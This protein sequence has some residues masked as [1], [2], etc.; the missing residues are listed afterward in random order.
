MSGYIQF[1]NRITRYKLQ[2]PSVLFPPE[3]VPIVLHPTGFYV[4]RALIQSEKILPLLQKIHEAIPKIAEGPQPLLNTYYNR[5]SCLSGILS[6]AVTEVDRAVPDGY[7]C[8]E[9][10][11]TSFGY[12]GQFQQYVPSLVSPQAPQLQSYIPALSQCIATVISTFQNFIETLR[13]CELVVKQSAQPVDFSKYPLVPTVV[14][15]LYYTEQTAV[16]INF[17]LQNEQLQGTPQ[18]EQL[19]NWLFLLSQFS[20]SLFTQALADAASIIGS[21]SVVSAASPSLLSTVSAI[22]QYC[23]SPSDFSKLGSNAIILMELLYSIEALSSVQYAKSLI[24]TCVQI[25]S[26]KTGQDDLNQFAN[27]LYPYVSPKLIDLGTEEAL[28]ANVA[29]KAA[30]EFSNSTPEL[31]T[32]TAVNLVRIYSCTCP[33]LDAG[34]VILS[35]IVKVSYDLINALFAVVKQTVQQIHDSYN[36]NL[37]ELNEQYLNEINYYVTTILGINA[38]TSSDDSLKKFAFCFGS[39]PRAIIKLEE[40]I[41]RPELK[42]VFQQL[43]AKCAAYNKEIFDW[44]HQLVMA[45]S[46]IVLIH[47]TVV[48]STLNFCQSQGWRLPDD[49][50]PIF[51]RLHKA[52]DSNT[53]LL[54]NDMRNIGVII[55][56]LNEITQPLTNYQMQLASIQQSSGDQLCSLA[57]LAISHMLKPL[58][59]STSALIDLLQ[60]NESDSFVAFVNATTDAGLKLLE[61]SLTTLQS[62]PY[63]ILFFLGSP[64]SILRC[65]FAAISQYPDF[66][67]PLFSFI[68]NASN[69]MQSLWNLCLS[70]SNGT[71]G[72]NE[73][74]S[75]IQQLQNLIQVVKD[76]IVT[77]NSLRAPMLQIELPESI[78]HVKAFESRLATIPDGLLKNTA[79]S[80]LN[81]ARNSQYAPKAFE[82][83]LNVIDKTLIDLIPFS[84]QLK[85]TINALVSNSGSATEESYVSDAAS[86]LA[87]ASKQALGDPYD[88]IVS[89][90]ITRFLNG[91]NAFLTSNGNDKGSIK[92]VAS[93]NECLLS[94]VTQAK[95]M[96]N[97]AFDAYYQ[98]SLQN[99]LKGLH[100]IRS[101]LGSEFPLDSSC[102]AVQNMAPITMYFTVIG[103]NETLLN[104]LIQTVEV[105]ILAQSG[106]VFNYADIFTPLVL[107]LSQQLLSSR[108]F[109]FDSIIGINDPEIALDYIYKRVEVFRLS[110]SSILK[111][112][113]SNASTSR[114]EI[115]DLLSSIDIA[116]QESVALGVRSLALAQRVETD[117]AFE[118]I[119]TY[120]E[121]CDS[122]VELSNLSLNYSNAR[123]ENQIQLRR[124]LRKLAKGFDN[125]I[126]IVETPS[127]Q[128]QQKPELDLAKLKVISNLIDIAFDVSS[129]I[130]NLENSFSQE[131][132][133]QAGD[134][135]LQSLTAKLTN[136]SNVSAFAVSKAVGDSATQL[137]NLVQ[138]FAP[139]INNLLVSAQNVDFGI[140]Y[141]PLNVGPET[142]KVASILRDTAKA[143][144]NLVDKIIIQPDP[145]A[146]GR[147]P[148]DYQLPKA[149]EAASN[150]SIAN[151]SLSQSQAALFAQFDTF[152]TVISDPNATSDTL[153]NAIFALKEKLD[154]F[155]E[156][157]LALMVTTKDSH[158]QLQL[159][160]SLHTV[161]TQ[162]TEIRY[163]LGARLM[164][165]GNFDAEMNESITKF[166]N[167]IQSVMAAA[168]NISA[169]DQQTGG[170]DN[171]VSK[172]LAA[173]AHAIEEMA[174]RLKSIEQAS[175]AENAAKATAAA[176]A[177]E[178]ASNIG[179]QEGSLAAFVILHANPILITA[180]LILNRA[181]EITKQMIARYGKLEN[182]QLLI[183]S[184]K[185]LGDSAALLIFAAEIVVNSEDEEAV[186]KVIAAAKIVK[187]AIAS[188]VA[189]VLVKG[190]DPE[191]IMN[192]HVRTIGE[193]ADEIIKRSEG[194]VFNIATEEEKKVKKAPSLMAQKLNLQSRINDIRKKLQE[195]EQILYKFRKRF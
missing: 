62:H 79:N 27:N 136:L 154:A 58:P 124:L 175:A 7:K 192:K 193:H 101:H 183:R 55:K 47:A 189:Q 13:K 31:A 14:A 184:A 174:Q 140:P 20:Q 119:T 155:A 102:K 111:A 81:S 60:L 75:S 179:A 72:Q 157:A 106:R 191:Q 37:V 49:L 1:A 35:D 2:D 94:T 139:E 163:A 10:M 142:Q 141:H 50:S 32:Y 160:T 44:I 46:S 109:N 173:T 84:V 176:Q 92:R 166:Y 65:C 83:F 43:G 45:L 187:A 73:L 156:D 8:T 122:F 78:K 188:L 64:Y 103:G 17:L 15:I 98:K 120:S 126:D 130:W 128:P 172:E 134:R 118:A 4:Q 59:Q 80:L 138:S 121:M 145:E 53:F 76:G 125:L 115:I 194:I 89:D 114:N 127:P 22:Q 169:A 131:M 19:S 52:L 152:R 69:P 132:Y 86:V 93:A 26:Q 162:F 104:P 87:I 113:Q 149:P 16:D 186:F 105:V 164:R 143:A 161:A 158:L 56:G 77:E 67:G 95:L 116:V 180:G 135:L 66:A 30:L 61:N 144:M 177:Q 68:E 28:A 71:A 33:D 190:G 74:N 185:E 24:P 34:E 195:E 6:Q 178:A 146:A 12:L 129:L 97:D 181:Q 39:L 41:S 167:S 51:D 153:V 29:I 182:E 40:S 21:I 25:Y 159:Q 100:T 137:S 151:E 110:E 170:G 63:S 171:D 38:I 70:I 85:D 91:M 90:Q 88:A 9:I 57:S 11:M 107:N 150:I 108:K 48:D 18:F 168:A 133:T 148:D 36:Q 23:D 5:I 42:I 112:I 96:T 3:K 99:G 147:L 54:A 82:S 165:T 117:E 123:E